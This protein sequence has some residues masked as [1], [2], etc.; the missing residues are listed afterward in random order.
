MMAEQ[1]MHVHSSGIFMR[2]IS[3]GNGR[4]ILENLM[5]SG[6]H[7]GINYFEMKIKQTN[8]KHEKSLKVVL[9]ARCV[10]EV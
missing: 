10:C 7:A 9:L 3:E 4:S 2:I 1:R 8:E 6:T 5:G